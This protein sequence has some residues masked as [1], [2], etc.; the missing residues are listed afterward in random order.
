MR[1]EQSMRCL[2]RGGRVELLRTGGWAG[3]ARRAEGARLGRA[4]RRIRRR[5]AVGIRREAAEWREN[6]GWLW[7]LAWLS[8]LLLLALLAR[9]ARVA[10]LADMQ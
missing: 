7:L 4:R 5:I 3:A 2:P 6:Q 1:H 9:I 8:L 10:L